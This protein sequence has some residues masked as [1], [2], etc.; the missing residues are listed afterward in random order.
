MRALQETG[1]QCHHISHTGISCSS[2][3]A[4]SHPKYIFLNGAAVEG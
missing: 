4:D 3:L 1:L 2:T